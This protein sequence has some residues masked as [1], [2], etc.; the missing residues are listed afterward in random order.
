MFDNAEIAL[1]GGKSFRLIAENNSPENIYIQS[2]TLNGQPYEKSFITH[3]D[4][5][6][7]GEL[8]FQMGSMPN[9]EF[10]AAPDNRPKSV[11]YQ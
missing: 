9:K 2:V 11:V 10:G 5:Q 7:G 6:N 8:V 4:I 3:T 1:P